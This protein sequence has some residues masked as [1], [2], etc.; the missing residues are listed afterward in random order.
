MPLNEDAADAPKL[1]LITTVNTA[2]KKNADRKP[3][4]QTSPYRSNDTRARAN[5]W[6]MGTAFYI[7]SPRICSGGAAQRC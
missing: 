2:A 3:R 5:S 7:P 6:L 4:G 1:H